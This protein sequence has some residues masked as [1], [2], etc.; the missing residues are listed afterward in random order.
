MP[1]SSTSWRPGQSGNLRGY[2]KALRHVRDVA[3]QHS[4]RA[5]EVLAEILNDADVAPACRIAAASELLNR[6]WGKSLQ[7]H[8]VAALDADPTN[9]QTL[10]TAT[11]EAMIAGFVAQPPTVSMLPADNVVEIGADPAGA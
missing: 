4:T 2:P 3:R 1:R 10:S 11:L 7:S 8:V 5:V 6:A 9:P